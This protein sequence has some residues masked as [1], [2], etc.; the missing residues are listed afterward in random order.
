MAAGSLCHREPAA[1]L[2]VT[3]MR[4]AG[5][6][7]QAD[8]MAPRFWVCVCGGVIALKKKALGLG[9]GDSGGVSL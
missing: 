6:G 8:L 3:E 4:E 2:G 9:M 5:K 1:G 7:S